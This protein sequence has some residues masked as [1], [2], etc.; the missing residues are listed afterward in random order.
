MAASAGPAP[1]VSR[2]NTALQSAAA[3]SASRQQK[4]IVPS[5]SIPRRGRASGAGSGAPW[6]GGSTRPG[7]A[8]TSSAAS[9]P[10]TTPR[11]VP[12]ATPAPAASAP[13]PA[14]ASPP[15][16]KHACSPERIGRPAWRSS[17]IACA[18]SA[19]FIAPNPQPNSTAVPTSAPYADTEA[20]T[21]IG[22]TFTTVAAST[23]RMLPTRCTSQ[24]VAGIDNSAP[25]AMPNRTMPRR[26]SLS[27]WADF[28]AG[29]R[30]AQLARRNPSARKKRANVGRA[31][32]KRHLDPQ[33]A[34]RLQSVL[35]HRRVG[36]Q[37]RELIE[38]RDHV[39]PGRA[40]L[41]RGG[42]G[43]HLGGVV[44]HRALHI[45]LLE[46]EH[47]DAYLRVQAADAEDADVGLDALD[48][49]HCGGAR[50]GDRVL[51]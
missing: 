39:R 3:P 12:A 32:R 9:T 47:R 45:G 14:P 26:A 10:A 40:E 44:D 35:A 1:V 50:G 7:A 21:A 18:L 33:L 19:T 28:T 51:P 8:S 4:A 38:R 16:L 17:E 34:E 46:V 11:C 25:E 36:D 5:A 43:H 13:T 2:R 30:D 24:A 15:K 22:T 41:V 48:G 23:A 49:L 31:L 6:W 29:T 27:P 42:H 37:M 20:I